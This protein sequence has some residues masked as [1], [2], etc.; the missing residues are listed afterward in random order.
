MSGWLVVPVE[1]PPHGFYLLSEDR[2]GQRRGREVLEAFLGRRQP[3]S[4][5]RVSRRNTQPIGCSNSRP[6]HLSQVR[7]KEQAEQEDMLSRLEDAVATMKGRDARLRPV[8]PSHVDLLRDFRLALLQR[9]G[10]LAD[11]M[12]DDI[13]LT[14]RLVRRTS[15]S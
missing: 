2:E 5:R 6:A 1:R 12:L 13:Q 9:D 4:R 7:R 10:R 15:G 11:Q 8:R 3:T 14:G